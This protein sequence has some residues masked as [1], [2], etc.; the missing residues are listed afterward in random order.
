M[1]SRS[2]Y[3]DLS[4]AIAHSQIEVCFVYDVDEAAFS[5]AS[6]RSNHGV[7]RSQDCDLWK[8]NTR[9]TKCLFNVSEMTNNWPPITLKMENPEC[10]GR[11]MPFRNKVIISK[12][13]RCQPDNHSHSWRHLQ[14]RSDQGCQVDQGGQEAQGRWQL[15][16]KQTEAGKRLGL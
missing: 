12:Q 3:H 16:K 11:K 5:L 2:V 8:T 6:G 7:V 13:R 15:Q 14:L 9:C 1:K 4:Q 10:F